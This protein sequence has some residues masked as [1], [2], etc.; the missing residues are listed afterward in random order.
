MQNSDY[1]F[2]KVQRH[3]SCPVFNYDILP[4]VNKEFNIGSSTLAFNEIHAKKLFVDANSLVVGSAVIS[5][6]GDK[7]VLAKGTLIGDKDIEGSVSS[8]E[9]LLKSGTSGQVLTSTGP[10]NTPSW[11]GQSQSIVE[12]GGATGTF[13]IAQGL[14]QTPIWGTPSAVNYSFYPSSVVVE[15]S[16]LQ[17]NTVVGSITLDVGFYMISFS[18]RF[19]SAANFTSYGL[20]GL[21]NNEPL[22]PNF[23]KNTAGIL[24]KYGLVDI[25][26][27]L[28]FKQETPLLPLQFIASF[29]KSADE[30]VLLPK[31]KIFR[32]Y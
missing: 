30:L 22:S 4:S 13:L 6:A 8:I 14:S 15:S 12:S 2:L 26:T 9:T 19:T 7:I 10:G 25:S 16:T 17:D 24:L 1:L 5:S 27:S 28:P 29:V 31:I 23:T 21:Y 11:Q 20:Y 3:K 32:I 18:C